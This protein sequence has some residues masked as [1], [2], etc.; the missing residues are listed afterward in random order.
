MDLI[1][2][3]YFYLWLRLIDISRPWH[4]ECQAYLSLRTLNNGPGDL[5]ITVLRYIVS[6]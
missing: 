5:G 1:I 3:T 4:H 2:S 6:S